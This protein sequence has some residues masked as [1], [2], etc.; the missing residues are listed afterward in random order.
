MVPIRALYEA[1]VYFPP[2]NY[3]RGTVLDFLDVLEMRAEV[4]GV[5]MKAPDFLEGSRGG[6]QVVAVC[7][8][9]CEPKNQFRIRAFPVNYSF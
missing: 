3:S 2:V 8:L 5:Y 4:S 1:Y 7:C 6:L 9:V